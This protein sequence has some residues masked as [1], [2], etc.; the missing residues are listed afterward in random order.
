MH[1]SRALLASCTEN[2]PGAGV[3]QAETAASQVGLAAEQAGLAAEQAVLAAVA[4]V[5][6]PLSEGPHRPPSCGRDLPEL[7]L[8]NLLEWTMKMQEVS[9]PQ[10]HRSVRSCLHCPQ[11]LT[12]GQSSASSRIEHCMCILGCRSKAHSRRSQAMRG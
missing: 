10:I 2:P 12:W 3:E 9:S 8:Q 1:K 7:V 5:D 4:Q 6:P 11:P